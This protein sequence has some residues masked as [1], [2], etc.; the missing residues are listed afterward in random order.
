MY[1]LLY[2][3]VSGYGEPIRYLF[4]HSGIEFEDFRIS[5]ADWPKYKPH[6][7]MEQLPILEIDGK[8]YHQSKAISRFIA[9]KTN[10]YG[11]DEFEAMEIDAT[12]DS[13]DNLM[14]ILYIYYREQDPAFKEKLKENAFQK[15]SFYL[16]KFE[17]Q[18]KKNG[19]Y[20]VGGKLSWAD[21]LWASYFE[22]QSLV[23]ARDPNRDHPELKK[24]VEQIRTSPNIKAYLEKRPKTEL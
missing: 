24:L 10:L 22:Y 3:N 5:F 18:V 17:A 16:D 19:G 9:K 2:F 15:L 12:V 14:Q 23:L 6:M 20:F 7:L 8:S 1:K 4:Y 13:I 21:L 11:L